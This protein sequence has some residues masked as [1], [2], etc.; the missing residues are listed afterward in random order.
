MNIDIPKQFYHNFL[1]KIQLKI[2]YIAYFFD[3]KIP[4]EHVSNK[5]KTSKCIFAKKMEFKLV[6]ASR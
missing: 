1:T 2:H 5:L 4:V 6:I 3:K